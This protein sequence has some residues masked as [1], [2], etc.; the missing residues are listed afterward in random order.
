MANFES[1]DI[2]YER[3]GFTH[4]V[5]KTKS[6][7]SKEKYF[8]LDVKEQGE[9]YLTARKTN[10]HKKGHKYLRMVLFRKDNF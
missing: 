3:N 6:Y 9:V 8:Q 4:C 1:I 10:P 5:G 7:S 2:C